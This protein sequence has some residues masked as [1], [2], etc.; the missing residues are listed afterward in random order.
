MLRQPLIDPELRPKA[1]LLVCGMDTRREVDRR[2]A[3][4]GG[5]PGNRG[6][7]GNPGENG[8]LTEPQLRIQ[9][10]ERLAQGD[11]LVQGKAIDKK[12]SELSFLSQ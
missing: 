10:S 4:K 2:L 11:P 6:D 9:L 12:E 8:V 1:R 5:L 7:G 3:G